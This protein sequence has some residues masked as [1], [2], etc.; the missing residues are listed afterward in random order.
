MRKQVL[1]ETSGAL[2]SRRSH[3]MRECGLQKKV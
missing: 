2:A 3:H 1:R